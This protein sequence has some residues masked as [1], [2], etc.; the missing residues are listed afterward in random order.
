MTLYQ[1]REDS[2]L[3]AQQVKKYAKGRVLDIGTGSGI[4]ALEAS[5]KKD[6]KHVLAIDIQKKVIEHCKKNIKNKKISFMQSDLFQNVKG[7]FDT[8]IFNPPY[9]P[10][11][12]KVKDLTIEGGKKG[13]E[14]LERFFR[15]VNDYLKR[16]GIVLI[17]FSSLTK[18]EK[19]NEII[20]SHGLEFEEIAKEHIFFED[21]YV[22]LIRKKNL[23]KEWESRGIEHIC[24]FTKG[25]RGILFKGKWNNKKVVIKAQNPASKAVGRIQ[26]EAFW[27]KRLNKKGIGPKLCFST[28][29]YFVYRY[30]PGLFILDYLKKMK[31]NKKTEKMIKRIIKNIFHQIYI[32]DSMYIDKEE[33][34][35][36]LKHIII[37]PQN[38]PV[39]VDFERCHNVKK[40]K[41]ITQFCQFLRSRAVRNILK[42]IGVWYDRGIGYNPRRLMELAK[43]YKHRPGQENLDKIM[44]YLSL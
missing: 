24:Y 13:Y 10:E 12:I 20:S 29:D 43:E 7:K 5:K 36:P 16:D 34:H 14:V 33:M 6:V 21:L 9:L 8:I 44:D 15:H 30:I 37:N 27:I 26:N 25:H 19:V 17:V 31:K 32:L 3:L 1:P 4:Q 18:K 42:N 22:Y 40:P 38:K 35:H 11:D 41:N 28:K 39:M 2:V 23:L